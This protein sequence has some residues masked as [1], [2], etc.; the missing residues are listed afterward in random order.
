MIKIVDISKGKV[1]ERKM[2]LD[3]ITNYQKS[4]AVW[5]EQLSANE[6]KQALKVSANSKLAALG[7]TPQEIAAIT[8]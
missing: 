4:E 3:E 7:L 1:T 5:A 8:G 6:T 2:N